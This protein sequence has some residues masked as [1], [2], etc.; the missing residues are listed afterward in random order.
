MTIINES[1]ARHYFGE[2]NPVGRRMKFGGGNSP[3]DMEIVGVVKDSK[4][5]NVRSEVKRFIYTPYTQSRGIGEMTFYV[6]TTQRPEAIATAL[7]RR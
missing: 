1:L 4:H 7:R 5:P 2:T 6:R 3:L